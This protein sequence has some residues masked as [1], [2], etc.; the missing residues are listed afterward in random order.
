ML[1]VADFGDN[2]QEF[3]YLLSEEDI[4]PVSYLQDI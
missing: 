4:F 1:E 2:C 3:W